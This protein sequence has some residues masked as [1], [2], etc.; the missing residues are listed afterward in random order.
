MLSLIAENARFFLRAA[1]GA[2][3]A[4]SIRLVMP[5]LLAAT[6]D[7][8][9]GETPFA[10]PAWIVRAYDAVGGRDF[11]R[12]HLYVVALLV[13]VLS[14]FQ[15]A[16]M[17]LR[18][19]ATAQGA[20]Q[21]AL[22][23]RDRLY[24]HLQKL[25]YQYHVKAETG[26]LIQRA[27]TDVET[28]RRFLAAQLIEAVGSFL[29]VAIALSVLY[30]R[31]VKL[32]LVSSVMVV[33]LFLYAYIFF[34]QIVKYFRFA[35]EAEGKM[36]AV[37][38]ENLTGVHVVRA[39]GRQRFEVD[40]FEEKSA[41]VRNKADKLIH[42][43]SVYWASSDAMTMVQICITLI[44]GVSMASSGA[45]TI[46]TL[47]VFLTYVGYIFWPVRQLGRILSDAG[48]SLVSLERID[49][50]LRQPAE[51][52]AENPITPPL[53]GDIVFDDV[54]FYYEEKRPV[55][56]N[57]SFTAKAGETVA[58]LGATGC[59]KSTLVQLLQRLYEPRG[60][61]ITIGGAPLEKIQKHYLRSRVG[62][63]LQ[64][65]FLYSKTIR[66]NVAIARR[67]FTEEEVLDASR[68]AQAEDFIRESVNGYETMVGERGVTLSGGQK[69]RLAI[70]RTLMKESDILIFDD[71]LSAVDTQT[72]AAIRKAL[73]ERRKGVTTFII[74]HRI[75]TLSEADKILVMDGGTIV[76]QGTHRELIEQPGLYQ[77][78]YR[79]QSDIEDE[80]LEEE[81]SFVGA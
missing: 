26:D 25:S 30:S 47:M 70:A 44:V 75:T 56:Q 2:A 10:A 15:C 3:M 16:F 81:A 68:V 9:I 14:L 8:I 54:S 6:V 64:E 21:V 45:I 23:L 77:R 65:P 57:V 48:K 11:F 12:A 5:L 4:V 60:G 43:L 78:I 71:S 32:S 66:Q 18:G 40:K 50:I 24:S 80:L 52:D 42:L 35:D 27:T 31:D 74:S 73:R 7:S 33:P 59:G 22:T 62:L 67:E 28:T 36:S 49:E 41:D 17:Y 63:V 51:E 1:L 46:G 53:S 39:F 61:R 37:L 34:K 13:V 76:Q 72:D 19:R 58:I 20:E 79:I 69:Q 55:L 38:Q 29:T